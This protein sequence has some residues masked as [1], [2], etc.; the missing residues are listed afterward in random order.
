MNE[1]LHMTIL[2]FEYETTV[3]SELDDMRAYEAMFKGMRQTN[4]NPE[5]H[6]PTVKQVQPAATEETK[7]STA[8]EETV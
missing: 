1:S 2:G 8:K 5:S 4:T 6:T 7:Q 3:V